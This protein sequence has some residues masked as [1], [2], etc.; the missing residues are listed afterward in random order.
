MKRRLVS[1][2]M[3]V[4][5]LCGFVGYLPQSGK[6]VI[7]ITANAKSF[8]DFTYTSEDLFVAD[9][10]LNQATL[11]GGVK[12]YQSQ[13]VMASVPVLKDWTFKQLAEEVI[14]NPS[15][16]ITDTFWINMEKS[17]SLDYVGKD[18]IFTWQQLMYETLIMDYLKYTYSSAE[19]KDN[20]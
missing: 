1:L 9:A 14:D 12:Y 18:N 11:P 10:L 3:T 15:N 2:L 8:D 5:M 17:V 13:P 19:Y 20:L 6:D 4:A 16:A 7:S